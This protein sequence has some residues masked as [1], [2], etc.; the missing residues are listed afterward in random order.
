MAMRADI[1]NGHNRDNSVALLSLVPGDGVRIV[2]GPMRGLKGEFIGRRSAT[3]ILVRAGGGM[4]IEI[5][6]F[7][8]EPAVRSRQSN[9]RGLPCREKRQRAFGRRST[10]GGGR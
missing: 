7:S 6:D 3:R 8:V 9:V 1:V 2:A 5:A 10:C 4:Y